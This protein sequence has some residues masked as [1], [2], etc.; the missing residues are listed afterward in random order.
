MSIERT[1]LPLDHAAPK[2]WQGG[3]IAA[4]VLGSV[5]ASLCCLPTAVAIALGLGLSAVPVLGQLLAYQRL[6]QIAGLAFAGIA[7]WWILR[8]SRAT[9][10]LAERERRRDRVPLYV[11][12]AFAAGFVV[13]NVAVIPLL[14]QLPRLLAGQ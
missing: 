11:F 14:E 3:S 1:S 5:L 7:V 12:G 6:F 13:L 8:R 4:G 2:P 9:C 10:G